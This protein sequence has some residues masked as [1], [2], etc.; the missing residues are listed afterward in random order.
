MAVSDRKRDG[1]SRSRNRIGVLAAALAMLIA[2]GACSA[3][4]AA[5]ARLAGGGTGA[6]ARGPAGFWTRSRLLGARPLGDAERFLPLPGQTPNAH[7][8]VALRVGALFESG[9]GGSHFCTASVVTSPGQNL[10]ITA[11]HCLNGGNG[12]GYRKNIVFIPGYRD[13]AAPFGIWT[14]RSL[15]VAPQWAQSA[16]PDY[17]VGFVVLE[18]LNGENIEQVLGGSKLGV[19]TAYR[20][21]VRVTGYPS[22]ADVPITC[23]NWTSEQSA[24]QLRFAC[25][26]Y[27]GGTSGSPWVTHFNPRSRTG[28]IVGVIGGYQQGGDTPAVSYSTF[29][30]PAVQQLYEQ[31][32]AEGAATGP[33]RSG[34]TVDERRGMAVTPG[35][36]GRCSSRAQGRRPVIW[37]LPDGGRGRLA[38]RGVRGRE[39]LAGTAPCLDERQCH[40]ALPAHPPSAYCRTARRP[41][42]EGL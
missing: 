41:P 27:T 12:T 26:G 29:F 22:S 18:P 42:G 5:N 10:L 31:A 33:E 7:P 9:V 1:M 16:D 35:C 34:A 36:S 3:A 13:G 4:P 25:G 19:D 15:L 39:R 14:P 40:G 8:V 37:R 11:A 23:L 30:G 24:T 2:L 38:A 6:L 20:Y 32:S 28:T 21:L 17:D